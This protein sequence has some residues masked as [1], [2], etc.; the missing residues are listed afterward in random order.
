MKIDNFF[1]QKNEIILIKHCIPL[2]KI[3]FQ[4]QIDIVDYYY[5]QDEGRDDATKYAAQA[6]TILGQHMATILDIIFQ[7]EEKEKE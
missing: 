4:K 1:K 5:L 2:K 6:L 3:C 7:S